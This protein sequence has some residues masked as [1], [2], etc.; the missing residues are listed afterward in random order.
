MV[1]NILRFLSIY[2]IS[3][4]IVKALYALYLYRKDKNN[5]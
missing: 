1:H 3:I 2:F 5:E 4:G